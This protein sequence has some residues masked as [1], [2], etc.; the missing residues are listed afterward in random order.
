MHK[1]E[2]KNRSRNSF[3]SNSKHNSRPSS[4][5]VEVV[6]PYDFI[7]FAPETIGDY[8]KPISLK[9]IPKHNQITLKERFSGSIDYIIKP[10]GKLALE[11][12]EALA[13][14]E[15][16]KPMNQQPKKPF[17]SGSQIRG[18][19]RSNIE[20]LSGS[21]PIFIDQT[22]MLYRDV[23]SKNKSSRY[24][25]KLEQASSL[26]EVKEQTGEKQNFNI[27][28]V[29]R[30]GYLEYRDGQYIIIPAKTFGTQNFLSV[31]EEFLVKENISDKEGGMSFF[32]LWSDDNKEWFNGRRNDIE[33]KLELIKQ[34]RASIKASDDNWEN[35]WNDIFL[36]EGNVN[37]IQYSK[38]N[39]E[40]KQVWRIKDADLDKTF[41]VASDAITEKMKKLQTKLESLSSYFSDSASKESFSKLIEAA[42][43]RWKIKA[44]KYVYY[45]I[46]MCPNSKYK[47]Y[48]TNVSWEFAGQESVRHISSDPSRYYNKGMLYSSTNAS[49][50]RT[51]YLINEPSEMDHIP[52]AQD[53]IYAYNKQWNKM[54][55]IR[56]QSLL[57]Q[58]YN[59]FPV[60]D[61]KEY[62]PKVVFYVELNTNDEKKLYIGRTPYFKIGYDYQFGDLLFYNTSQQK[63]QLDY[64]RAL[65]GFVETDLE[66]V[67]TKDKEEKDSFAYKSRLRFSP[68]EFKK[69]SS[70]SN[71]ELLTL[72]KF[73]LPTPSAT[74]DGMYIHKKGK[75][76]E[77]V[78]YEKKGEQKPV[79]NGTKVYHIQKV[80]AVET[81]IRDA[82]NDMQSL[83]TILNLSS[84]TELQGK[85][86]F[87]NL[88]EQELGLLLLALDISQIVKSKQFE[89]I[90]I[91][92]EEAQNALYELIGGAKAY[93]YGK[94][95]IKV[96]QVN[97]DK[98]DGDFESLITET[99]ELM[100][101]Q[102]YG[103]YIDKFLESFSD[104]DNYV[105]NLLTPYVESKQVFD[106]AS[107]EEK[108]VK[109]LTWI[110]MSNGNKK[111]GYDKKQFLRSRFSK[112]R[113][114]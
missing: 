6:L 66:D 94:V 49:S 50:K 31:R 14:Q 105:N 91:T 24:K 102:N 11:V 45:Q 33:A 114:L 81:A 76:T 80:S 57:K 95:Q 111:V 21:F 35:E 89:R 5:P 38:V 70:G 68:I 20:I 61:K 42:L 1:K 98:V 99:T 58:F 51:H 39:S 40:G 48:E 62:E 101:Q 83:K 43:E 16:T 74:A 97:V 73:L 44:E 110:Q 82:N 52:V 29:V 87:N 77:K 88:S 55:F 64:A 93:G 37:K 36:N 23:A 47:P 59:I 60:G 10:Q 26:L 67:V 75:M 3:N 27:S 79:L 9:Q 78:T 18:K 46:K 84:E 72:K 4:E 103:L 90:G 113:K 107:G 7:P 28:E 56:N 92:A 17:V 25:E 2:Q 109:H 54:R 22:E 96:K 65:F 100:P 13:P 34:R 32:Y 71:R 85:V 104:V 53:V 86:Y 15:M 12:R 108:E 30:A 69:L 63:H 8:H 112:A 41:E 19:I 106:F